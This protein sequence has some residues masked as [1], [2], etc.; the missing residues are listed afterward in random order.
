VNERLADLLDEERPVRHFELHLRLHVLVV[1]LV[2]QKFL[3]VVALESLALLSQ[4]CRVA[5]DSRRAL[6]TL[7]QAVLLYQT[8]VI[9]LV[10]YRLFGLLLLHL[11]ATHLDP[12]VV[13][14]R[15]GG[16]FNWWRDW[17][18]GRV[19]SLTLERGVDRLVLLVHVRAQ[20]G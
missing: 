20:V 12:S 15:R 5:D 11:L 4:V 1:P 6:D 14:G 16:L 2:P 8:A 17:R 19:G 3:L 7:L 13:L 10:F 18:P 9:V